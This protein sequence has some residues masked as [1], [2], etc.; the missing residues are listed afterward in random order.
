MNGMKITQMLIPILLLGACTAAP[1]QQTAPKRQM[2]LKRLST[3]IDITWLGKRIWANECA[4]SVEGLVSWNAGEAFP[5]LGIGHFI[6]YPEGVQEAFDESMPR[7][8]AYAKS[9]GV[10][11]PEYFNGPAPWPTKKAFEADRSGLANKMRRWLAE[12]VELQTQFIILRSRAA[13]AKMMRQSRN[14]EAVLAHYNALAETT[15]GMYCLVDYVN[16]KGEGI[17]ASERYNG[18]GWGLLQVLEEMRGTP[19]GR[20]ATAEFSRAASA[21]MRRRVAN[22]PAARGEQRWLAGWLNRCNTYK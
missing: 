4:G 20:A 8:V 5:S 9:R 2:Q 22:A 7:F 15:Q 21:V 14:P 3:N 18:Y 17:K 13:L 6:W 12:N 16:F 19:Q 10:Q 11:V 1:Q